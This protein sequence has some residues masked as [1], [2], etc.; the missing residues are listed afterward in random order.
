MMKSNLCGGSSVFRPKQQKFVKYSGLYF[1]GDWFG[2]F[3]SASAGTFP[4]CLERFSRRLQN[5]GQP[6][7]ILTGKVFARRC[8]R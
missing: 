7:Q 5:L 2:V 3:V 4:V 6:N 8:Q 1:P